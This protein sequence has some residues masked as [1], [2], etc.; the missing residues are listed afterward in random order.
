MKGVGCFDDVEYLVS[1][2]ATSLKGWVKVGGLMFSLTHSGTITA[3]NNSCTDTPLSLASPDII[4]NDSSRMESI[5]L[6]MA[7]DLRPFSWPIVDVYNN[8]YTVHLLGPGGFRRSCLE[9][10]CRPTP[11]VYS[12]G[13]VENRI[14]VETYQLLQ[15]FGVADLRNLVSA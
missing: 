4:W 2:G 5:N 14:S 12:E 3:L 6:A 11:S 13:L 10:F 1:C 7:D 9:K 15:L 8:L